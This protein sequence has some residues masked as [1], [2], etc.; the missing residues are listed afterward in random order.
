MSM[1]SWMLPALAAT[2]IGLAGMLPAAAAVKLGVLTCRVA[3]GV[4]LVLGSSKRVY[5]DF[6][7][8]GY[9]TEHYSGRINKL[10]VDV[11]FTTSGVIV[12][13]VFA[14]HAGYSRYA[15]AGHYGGA[16]AEATLVAGL[17][18]NA[19]VGGSGRS[20]ALQPFSVSGQTGLG[21]AAGIAGLDL[22][23]SR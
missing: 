14:A 4:G 3:P 18:A 7:P 13:G 15:L 6:S 5:C 23:A 20:F 16:T 9:Q 22:N 11:G 1:K 10:G 12:W 8:T 19:L 2:A 21:I 17:G